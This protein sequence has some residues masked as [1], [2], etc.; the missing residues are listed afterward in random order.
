ME[1]VSHA[2]DEYVRGDVHTNAVESFWTLFKR[3]FH[4]TFHRMSVKHL[5]RYVNEFVG[6]DN[7]RDRD[8]IDQM[9]HVVAGLV[10]NAA[11]VPG[12][13]RGL[14]NLDI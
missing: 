5:Q 12:P 7:M 1:T 14:A 3:G 11:G 4:K 13:D 2:N 9:G 10:G 6:R 8:T